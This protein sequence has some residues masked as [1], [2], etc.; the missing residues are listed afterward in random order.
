MS[1][2]IAQFY[3]FSLFFY[4]FISKRSLQFEDS[5]KFYKYPNVNPYMRILP[6]CISPDNKTVIWDGTERL[7]PDNATILFDTSKQNGSFVRKYASSKLQIPV[8]LSVEAS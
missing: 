4:H 5:S 8:L 7:S 1:L 2:E 6:L 3:L